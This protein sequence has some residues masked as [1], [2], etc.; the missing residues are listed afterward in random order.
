MSNNQ[1]SKI[2][3]RQQ[4]HKIIKNNKIVAS[5]T[6]GSTNK[7]SYEKKICKDL[8]V[9]F[10]KNYNSTSLMNKTCANHNHKKIIIKE[11][12]KLNNS[13][14]KSFIMNNNYNHNK[15]LKFPI[16][17]KKNNK[18]SLSLKNLSEEENGLNA[19]LRSSDKRKNTH[20]KIE[21]FSTNSTLSIFNIKDNNKEIIKPVKIQ[22]F[23][24]NNK[25]K[26]NFSSNLIERKIRQKTRTNDKLK[27]K[28][29]KNNL[30]LDKNSKI[31]FQK[32][33]KSYVKDNSN[34]SIEFCLSYMKPINKRR[35]ISLG[36]FENS[37][38][39]TNSYSIQDLNKKKIKNNNLDS[40]HLLFDNISF[41]QNKNSE[42]GYTKGRGSSFS[43]KINLNTFFKSSINNNNSKK[44]VN[45]SSL[46]N[47]LC[48]KYMNIHKNTV[49]TN[50]LFNINNKN[51]MIFNYKNKSKSKY[52]NLFEQK[53]TNKNYIK[54]TNKLFNSYKNNSNLNKI[55]NN[56][57]KKEEIKC[58]NDKYIISKKL[59]NI[60][61]GIKSLLDGLYTIY[62]NANVHV[63]VNDV[64]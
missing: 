3:S 53:K 19:Q 28:Q 2:E 64:K 6:L 50:D 29:I 49:S 18:H 24:Y 16:K 56:N 46:P 10:I 26:K 39:N 58:D 15:H 5:N 14:K 22:C 12:S 38:S 34:K 8:S 11:K 1:K 44:K 23:N 57:M 51:I 21:L 40:S 25:M 52:Q 27:M 42:F 60:Q 43:K 13:R 30:S 36:I 20:T 54:L 17:I 35:N 47:L 45:L 48:N 62:L 32:N 41:S 4:N 33:Q 9:N 59:N 61:L 63:H 37:N 31:Y 7:E 55:K